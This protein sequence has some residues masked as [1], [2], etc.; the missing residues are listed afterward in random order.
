MKEAKFITFLAQAIS[1]KSLIQNDEYFY[2]YKYMSFDPDFKVLELIKNQV[3]KYTK[4]KFLDDEYENDIQINWAPF[5]KSMG[6]SHEIN[7]R[8]KQEYGEKIE[9]KLDRQAQHYFKYELG[10]FSLSADPFNT[11]MWARYADNSKGFLVEFKFPKHFS[12]ISHL[13]PMQLTYKKNIQKLNG[14]EI[15]RIFLEAS[16]EQSTIDQI[17]DEKFNILQKVLFTKASN[18][19]DQKEYRL[20]EIELSEKEKKINELILRKIPLEYISSIVYGM[21]I[22][23]KNKETIEEIIANI[24]LKNNVD[25]QTFQSIKHPKYA[26]RYVADNHPRI[27]V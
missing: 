6:I 9:V 15:K 7:A 3:L 14:K 11:S 13:I 8:Y 18:W 26:T 19:K 10:V 23:Q 12:D 27:K 1:E 5:L 24:N 4:P 2:L 22:D 17:D 25:I 21:N 16:G 20:L